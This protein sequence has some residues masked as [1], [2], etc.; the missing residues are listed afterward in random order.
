MVMRPIRLPLDSVN[1]ML[2]SGPRVIDSGLA[3]A[4]MPALNSVMTPAGVMRPILLAPNSVNH[5]LPS[6][7]AAMSTGR[8]LAV[9]PVPN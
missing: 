2:P 7:P 3:P 8:A 5:R 1:H 6:G 9:M 4:V